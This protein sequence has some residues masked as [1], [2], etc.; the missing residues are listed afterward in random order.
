MPF[1][2]PKQQTQSGFR[3]RS[4]KEGGTNDFNELRFE[5]ERG[6]EQVTLHAQRDYAISVENDETNQVENN[7]SVSVE[8]GYYSTVVK[9]GYKRTEVTSDKSELHAVEIFENADKQIVLTVGPCEIVIDPSMIQLTA[10]QT[11]QITLDATGVT[12]TGT[13]GTVSVN[14]A[15]VAA[16]GPSVKMNALG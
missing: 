6:A 5:D 8:K 2:L 12:I 10:F 14:A 1:D 7:L 13:G 3:T 9:N 11:N 15:G 16:T 4:T